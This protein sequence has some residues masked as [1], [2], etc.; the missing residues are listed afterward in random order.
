MTQG[1]IWMPL[2]VGDYLRDTS[3]LTTEQHGAYLLLIMDYFMNGALPD[4]DEVLAS[5]TKMS[6]RKWKSH[7]PTIARYF[8]IKGGYLYHSRIEEEILR[9][10]ERRSRARENG[11]KG[12]RPPKKKEGLKAVK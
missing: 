4:D 10:I 3:R 6:E 2:Y 7:K 8:D 12:G 9:G 5:V 1:N 11:K